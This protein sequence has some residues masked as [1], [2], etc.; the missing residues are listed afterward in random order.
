MTLALD[1]L[2]VI[3]LEQAVAAPYCSHRLREAGADVIKIERPEGDF[4]RGYD[5]AVAGQSAYFVWANSGKRSVVLD[6]KREVDVDKLRAMLR[7]A[8]VFV[9]NLKPGV[10]P[11][12]GIDL[13]AA[14]RENPRLITCC[15]AGYSSAGPSATK[16]AYD[17]LIQAETGLASITGGPEAPGRVGVS[18]CDI[19]CGM[20]AY[21]NI[22]LALLARGSN[23]GQGRHLEITLFD[24]LAQW[25]AVPYLLE[26]YGGGAPERVGIAHPG[27]SP[28][29][30][31][32]SADGRPFVLA[33]QSEREW[34]WLCDGFLERPD[35]KSDARTT[36]NEARLAHRTL[37]DGAVAER[38]A[39]LDYA[40]I[41]R[42]L[43]LANI[44]FAPVNEVAALK[45]HADFRTRRV[46]VG[47][48]VVEVPV[49]PGA[50]GDGAPASVPGL[51]EH[52]EAVLAEFGL[53]D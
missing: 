31:F 49:T 4:A 48:A 46:A 44:A 34:Q 17:L 51:G 27:I 33:V 38:A 40:E 52:T 36:P 11:R 3:A 42:Q 50:P 8:D 20:Y 14:R 39:T 26:R 47:A 35:W 19:A 12:L 21:D 45:A 29:G 32:V 1:G 9:Q 24:A 16:K 25:M 43:E 5:T 23:G 10:L 22:L 37:V 13:D 15:I 41:A 6:L 18:I 28:Y 53:T 7:E 2:T 30:V